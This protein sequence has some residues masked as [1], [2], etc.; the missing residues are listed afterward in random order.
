[1]DLYL[2]VSLIV[3]PIFLVYSVVQKIRKKPNIL[4][5]STLPDTPERFGAK[6]GLK[7][8]LLLSTT[9]AI[10]GIFIVEAFVHTSS[11]EPSPAPAPKN[12]L[13]YLTILILGLL[14]LI[15]LLAIL[16]AVIYGTITGYVLG[17]LISNFKHRF[18]SFMFLLLGVTLCVVTTTL[19]YTILNIKVTLSFETPPALYMS[20]GIYES[21]PFYIGIPS[22]IY[23]L[24]GGF[25]S[26]HIFKKFKIEGQLS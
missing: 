19:S 11:V 12:F 24:S 9:Y 1:M 8:G 10:L 25:A 7:L 20:G 15:Y 17:I 21:Y 13:M 16:P 5:Q 23:I 26:W 22:L 2:F 4:F 18:S 6:F 3:I 14:L